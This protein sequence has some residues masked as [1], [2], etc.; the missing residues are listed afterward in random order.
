MGGPHLDVF[1]QLFDEL[2]RQH[3][4]AAADA[5]RRLFGGQGGG[6]G[7]ASSNGNKENKLV[8]VEDPGVKGRKIVKYV[9]PE[10]MTTDK[11]PSVFQNIISQTGELLREP[12]V[13]S[14]G[15]SYEKDDIVKWVNS[16]ENAI[17]PITNKPFYPLIG[18]YNFALARRIADLVEGIGGTVYREGETQNV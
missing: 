18:F 6:G 17:S 10:N 2:M 9:L 16:N 7:A 12:V 3:N 1:N 14:D 4:V 11:I 15:H 13:M 8:I 5:M